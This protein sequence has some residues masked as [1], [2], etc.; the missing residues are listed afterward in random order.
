MQGV[1]CSCTFFFLSWIGTLRVKTETIPLNWR[2]KL[3][4]DFKISA[5]R[6]CR[7]YWWIAS[8]IFS[9]GPT[10]NALLRIAACP[11]PN[12]LLRIAGCPATNALLFI[13]GCPTPNALL[14]ISVP[15]FVQMLYGARLSLPDKI[16]LWDNNKY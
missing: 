2:F 7:W 10:P 8:V 1:H 15:Y 4:A 14:H 11:T 12:S 3:L 9:I 16:W 13:A 5:A 6:K